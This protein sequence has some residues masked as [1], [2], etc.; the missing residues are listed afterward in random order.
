MAIKAIVRGR[1]LELD[2]PADWPDGTEV[3]IQPLGQRTNGDADAMSPRQIAETLAAM[4]AAEPMDLSDA[5]QAAWEAE[6]RARKEGEKTEFFE[7]V[8]KLSGMWEW[9]GSSSTAAPRV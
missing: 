8:K 6:L 4:D 2:V 3:E 9:L 1:R 5:E 7:H